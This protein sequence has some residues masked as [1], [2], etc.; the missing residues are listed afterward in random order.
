MSMDFEKIEL[1][2]V[3]ADGFEPEVLEGLDSCRDRIKR[4]SVDTSPERRGVSTTAAV[5][6]ELKKKGYLTEVCGY[7]VY[8]WR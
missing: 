2:K 7:V 3:E 8:G 5:V 6:A 4:I 1:L